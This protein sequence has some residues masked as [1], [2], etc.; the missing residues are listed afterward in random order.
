MIHNEDPLY[1][2][3]NHRKINV[4]GFFFFFSN[5]D[6]LKFGNRRVGENLRVK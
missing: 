6:P 4:Q 2:I 3:F 5:E 1:C